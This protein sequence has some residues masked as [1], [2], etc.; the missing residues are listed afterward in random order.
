MWVRLKLEFKFIKILGLLSL[1]AGIFL[2]LSCF[3]SAGILP[4]KLIEATRGFRLF[5]VCIGIL[6]I[7][8]GALSLI[9]P[10][11][12]DRLF[13]SISGLDGRFQS[14]YFYLIFCF[15]C[16]VIAFM[17]GLLI[18][19]SGSGISPDSAYY[20]KTG[21]NI[22]SGQGFYQIEGK[23]YTDWP[24]LYP[25]SIVAFMHL[26]IDT[27]QAAR[28][29]PILCFALLMFPAFFLGK[30]LGNVFTG[31][32]TCLIFLVFAP[33]LYIT[34]Y[35]LA[36]MPYV[37]FCVL[38]ILFLAKFVISNEPGIKNLCVA[39]LFT[40]LAILTRWPGFALLPAG[41]IAIIFKN[42]S[43][44]KNTVY[45]TVLFGAISIIPIVLWLYRS[46][47][48]TGTLTGDRGQSIMGLLADINATI[49]TI[50][51][52]FFFRLLPQELYSDFYAY[53]GLVIIVACFILLAVLVKI[54]SPGRK[55]VLEYL[56]K[57]YIE[58]LYAAGYIV[59]IIISMLL[60]SHDPIDTRILV[61]AYPFLILASISFVFFAYREIKNPAIKPTLFRVIIIF[62]LLFLVL[63]AG[64]ALSYYQFAK[65]G[66]GYNNPSWRNE[67]GIG[68]AANNVPTN[69]MVYSDV[70]EGVGFLI[71]RPVSFLPRSGDEIAI[72]K[73][74][75]K[76][77]N[78]EQSYIICFKEFYH[79]PYLLS[80][81]ELAE[82][83]R[84]YGVLAI[85]ADFPTSTIWCVNH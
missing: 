46:F 15:A 33:L 56:R 61:P 16:F 50:F 51:R 34:S 3:S 57:N 13:D 21:E 36:E 8:F 55:V 37:L 28:L 83:N 82:A 63:Q 7:A 53:T 24:P 1:A 17:F 5:A 23:P 76:L 6:A 20:I 31:Y 77:R 66:Q 40:A 35:A 52:D 64:G 26:G 81:S 22:F 54:S 39:G 84:K 43:R 70:A 72:D 62:C 9:F 10:S 47:T 73:F 4:D 78:E 30:I 60:W 71:K 80:N 18:T 79:R 68:W 19:Q 44:L 38:A 75:V 14:R 65:H 32:F 29:V 69:A 2:V 49:L 59:T 67:Q 41:L 85:I 45:Q 25:L 12:L 74:L 27:E 42:K 48:L 11:R 58:I